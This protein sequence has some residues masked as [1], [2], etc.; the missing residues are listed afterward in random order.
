M[1]SLRSLAKSKRYRYQMRQHQS[2]LQNWYCLD[3]KTVPPSKKD[4]ALVEAERW[5]SLGEQFITIS[6]IPGKYDSVW[7][8]DWHVTHWVLRIPIEKLR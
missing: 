7:I 4:K 1:G 2:A 5:G 8:C 6:D 3:W